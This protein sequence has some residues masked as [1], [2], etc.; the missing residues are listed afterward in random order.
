MSNKSC[1]LTL[2]LNCLSRFVQVLVPI[3][4]RDALAQNLI[5]SRLAGNT[6][7]LLKAEINVYAENSERWTAQKAG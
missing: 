6:Y 1:L 2:F 4:I 3:L 7:Q 5:L